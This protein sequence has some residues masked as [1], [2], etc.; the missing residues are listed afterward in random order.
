MGKLILFTFL[1]VSLLFGADMLKVGQKA[2]DFALPDANGKIH[3]LSDY[4]GE[5]VVLYFYPKDNSPG[6]TNEACNLRDN[7]T[8]LQDR[9][10]I[11]LGVS[12]DDGE[13]HKKFAADHNLPFTLLSDTAKT[14]A[15]M[16]GAKRGLLGFIGAK[17]ITYLIDE[18]GIIIHVFDDVDTKAH[19]RQILDVLDKSEAS[20]EEK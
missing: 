1:F 10:L 12:Y 2:P 9:N 4:R 19:S 11:I 8:A 15:E 14:V 13:S 6:C 17:R 7:Y 3:K 5:K 18:N 16:Y 20:K